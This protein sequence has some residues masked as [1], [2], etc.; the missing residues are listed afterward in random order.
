MTSQGITYELALALKNA[1]FPQK[2]G[3]IV[4]ITCDVCNGKDGCVYQHPI[5]TGRLDEKLIERA[6]VY[7]TLSELIEACEPEKADEFWVGMRKGIWETI[8]N[9]VGYFDYPEK[10]KDSN[11]F[12]Q[13]NLKEEGTTPEEAVAMLYLALHGNTILQ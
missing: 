12:V 2:N 8:L 7:P 1:G 11:G 9:Y 3:E 10:F 4:H 5:G 13:V 6:L